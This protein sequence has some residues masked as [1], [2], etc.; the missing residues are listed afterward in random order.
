MAREPRGR[1]S[2]YFREEGSAEQTWEA[3]RGGRKP[4]SWEIP[5]EISL[6]TGPALPQSAYTGGFLCL[7]P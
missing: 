4:G 1:G 2:R 5:P 7:I 6:A 3:L